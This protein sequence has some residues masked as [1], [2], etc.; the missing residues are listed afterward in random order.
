MNS[1]R[2]FTI[3]KSYSQSTRYLATTLGVA[4]L[5]ATA[6]LSSAFS[7]IGYLDSMSASPIAPVHQAKVRSHPGSASKQA[8]GVSLRAG[9][10]GHVLGA[11]T[12]NPDAISPANRAK[13]PP[14]GAAASPA[15]N[16]SAA[17]VDTG[18]LVNLIDSQ[19]NVY[20][21]QWRSQA[22]GASTGLV[23]NGNG[24]TTAVIAGTPIVTYVPAAPAN[25]FTG[26]SLAGFGSLSAGSLSSGN[27]AISGDL[28]VS[29]PAAI[30][31]AITAATLNTSGS[32][33][34]GGTLSAA[35]S[36][37][38]SLT[39]SG[40]ASFN[41]STTIAGL[42]VTSFNPG[43]T[44]GSI[45]FQGA[46]GL[47]Q[48]NAN[49]FFDGTNH[50]LGI[51]T[52]T[53][54]AALT[55]SGN[56]LI[57]G[58]ATTSG[59]L[60]VLASANI[61]AISVA[62][63]S[64]LAT[65]SATTIDVTGPATLQSTLSVSG[66]SALATTSVTSFNDLG[67]ATITGSTTI[68]SLAAGPVRSTASGGL[69]NAAINLSTGD[70][71]GL[72]PVANGGTGTSSLASLTVGSNL[73]ITGGQNVLVGIPTQISLGAN[74]VT[75]V[76]TDTNVTGSLA[77]NTLTL[78]W[79]GTLAAGRLNS[80]VVQAIT[81]DTNITGA[82]ANQNLSLGWQGQLA[83]ARGGTGTGALSQYNLLAGNGTGALATISP[84]I[85]FQVLRSSG[86]TAY[87]VY[88]DVAN[89]L[90]AGSN[91]NVTGTSTI[92]VATSPSF[93]GLNVSGTSSIATLT[94]TGNVGI[95]T[96]T[97]TLG[98]LTMASGA[99]VSAGGVW[100]NA[101][102]RNLK[103][104]FSS[105]SPSTMLQ[106]ID[107]LPVT[108]WNYKDEDP[109][110]KH[111]GP[112][113]QDFYAIF[114]VGDS[115]TSIS[116]I[117][118][119]GV[120]LLGIQALDQKITALQ[121]SLTSN[122]ST[123]NLT[124]LSGAAFSGDSVGQARIL[125]GESSVRV[126]FIEPYEYQPIVT[127]SPVGPAA[128]QAMA[129][130]A[131]LSDI[132]STGFTIE[133]PTNA[134]QPVT[135]DWHSFASPRARLAV[136]D[137][138]SQAVQVVLAASMSVAVSSTPSAAQIGGSG[139]VTETATAGA[140]PAVLDTSTPS[141][142]SVAAST[143]ATTTPQI[144]ATQ[145]SSPVPVVSA[146]MNTTEPPTRTVVTTPS[147]AAPVPQST[148]TVPLA[149]SSSSPEP[150]TTGIPAPISSPNTQK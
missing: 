148:L 77:N 83:V 24:Q 128:G 58:N 110:I 5:A 84:G 31:G 111:I 93:S 34:V 38:S 18:T 36:S 117:D 130:G 98:P 19:L 15:V 12:T 51:G 65:T 64:F 76:A 42:T 13:P 61:G 17:S 133:V 60:S 66:A 86:S 127:F 75:A 102:D 97:P 91:I 2:P 137:G 116:T 22:G 85:A 101:S 126:I 149:V 107:E 113:A 100:A 21:A 80:S 145:P 150:D 79:N 55:V 134:S 143:A 96:T 29:G 37:L 104:N 87:P 118:P 30:T 120:A 88:S 4:A 112:V 7:T 10:R 49:L 54:S 129:A 135:F 63:N 138:T 142:N 57:F 72:L 40:P 46:S 59:S 45:A 146:P 132:S 44:V 62:G 67:A 47:T 140:A 43:L 73:S 109:S 50:W 99:Y 141:S 144:G 121:G 136:S 70:T 81:N 56:A 53:P 89:L 82:I 90:T 69:Y 114:R 52:T 1:L 131:Y 48:D 92:A 139:P 125:E 25:S 108:E 115:S 23:Q 68:S 74:V 8:V 123:S 3:S 20:L 103:E 39:I 124:I 27:T 78:G 35:T 26:T 95:G 106:G 41:G 16:I 147:L 105:V 14:S 71:T 6:V 94:T 119:A 9:A 33:T 122:A 11:S 28:S 32:A